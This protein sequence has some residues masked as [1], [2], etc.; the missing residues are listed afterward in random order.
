MDNGLDRRDFLKASAAALAATQF[1][2]TAHA[3]E[4]GEGE[5]PSGTPA[6]TADSMILIWIPGGL[7]QVEFWDPKPFRD[8]EKGMKGSD[9]LSPCRTS[10]TVVDGLDIGDHMPNIA[11]VMDRGGIIRSLTST[12]D[13][14]FDHQRAQYHVI[15]GYGFPSGFK[16][17]GIGAKISRFLGPRAEHMPPFIV[18]GRD[19]Q[20]LGP[21]GP[22]MR[23]FLNALHG[24]GFYGIKHAPFM[25]NE[26]ENGMATLDAV[27]G[28]NVERL[29]RRQAYLETI[30]GLSTAELREANR[31]K[32]YLS[33][34]EGARA[35]MDS[36]MK[37][38]FLYR[39][40][41][42][43]ESIEA[44]N[45]G[46]RFGPS[47]LVARRLVERGARFVQV[48]FPFRTFGLFDTHKAG[49]KTN[50]ARKREIDKPIA[51]LV[52]DLEERGLL[53]RTLIVVLSEFG[54]TLAKLKNPTDPIAF[55]AGGSGEVGGII[56]DYSDGSDIK[57]ERVDMFG[58]HGHFPRCHSAVF[59]GGGVK[60]GFVYGKSADRH[61]MI[62]VENPVSIT[63]L[64]ATILQAMGISQEA[65]YVSEERPIYMTELG[66][67]EAVNE[68]YA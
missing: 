5:N 4:Y 10:H 11:E 3:Q 64:H 59:F 38:A 66:K 9:L 58:M 35:M 26:P 8:F 31:V 62:P 30:S 40:Q 54:R 25:I 44:Y 37:E 47:C 32:D 63:D 13:L 36:S 68:I 49:W 20:S 6:A 33:V 28:M 12:H 29:D 15:T 61:P 27:A 1:A 22:E 34:V 23:K 46:H 14:D 60:K 16:A 19:T 51:Q 2:P 55:A 41:E 56:D 53:D 21:E 24:P 43:P 57:I 65:Y 45:S 50:A 52:R 48:E 17:P 18:I 7:S 67:G 39:E 42:T